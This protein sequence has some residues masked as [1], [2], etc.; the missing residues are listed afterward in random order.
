MVESPGGLSRLHMLPSLPLLELLIGLS[1]VF[2]PCQIP[3]SGE[4]LNK[5]TAVTNGN[6]C[7]SEI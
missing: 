3:L 6:V 5:A 7:F 4:T 1:S 2:F